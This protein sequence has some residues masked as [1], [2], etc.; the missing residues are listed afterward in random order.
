MI[1]G[2]TTALALGVVPNFQNIDPIKTAERPKKKIKMPSKISPLSHA[3]VL[4]NK[5]ILNDY[6]CLII[7]YMDETLQFDQ[8]LIGPCI[9][10]SLVC[11]F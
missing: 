10:A 8:A 7:D 6:L 2:M 9:H 11:H 1:N 4:L 3:D 5:F